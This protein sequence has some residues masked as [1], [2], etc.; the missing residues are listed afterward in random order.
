MNSWNLIGIVDPNDVD[1]T[2]LKIDVPWNPLPN[3]PQPL[4]NPKP[5]PYD[6]LTASKVS[7]NWRYDTR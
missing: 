4:K 2:K 1:N 7:L 6:P 3:V 5:P